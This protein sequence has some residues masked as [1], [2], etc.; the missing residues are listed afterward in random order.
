MQNFSA[1]LAV[2]ANS[3]QSSLIKELVV[4]VRDTQ[5]LE[6][7]F[8]PSLNSYAF[9]N[10]IE[11]V[12]M[13]ENLYIGNPNKQITY[14]AFDNFNYI[15]NHTAIETLYRL[16]VGG[17][18]LP[19]AG[20]TGMFR[21][22]EQDD[23]YVVVPNMGFTPQLSVPIHYSL[24]TPAYS[25]PEVVYTTS[26]T[27]G[28]SGYRNLTWSFSVDSGFHYLVRLHF[29]EFQLEVTHENERV[30]SILM[31]NQMAE[32]EADVIRWSGGT[33]NPV[34]R[35]YVVW[36]PEL[37]GPQIKQDMRLVMYPNPNTSAL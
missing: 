23:S 24:A 15:D 28:K 12:S 35:D 21:L 1:F 26:R 27:L 11:V 7:T 14:V 37:A 34:S 31:N 8:S 3:R 29:C 33:G 19:N 25:A 36:V 17:S 13:P 18:S 30:F 32:E 10:G 6:I 9:I 22:W 4:N 20:D 2:S 5:R 16:N